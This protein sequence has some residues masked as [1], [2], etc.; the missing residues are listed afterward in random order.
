MTDDDRR[1]V[2]QTARDYFD[3]WFEGDRERM[4]RVLHPRLAKRRAGD[5]GSELVEVPAEDLIDD[6]ASGPQTGYD[7][8]YEVRIVDIGQDMA[9]VVV[10]SDPF[11]EYLHLGRFDGGWRIVNSFYRRNPRDQR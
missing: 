7:R 10:R 4:A 1:A 5:S 11:N 3:S 9:S 6:V 8:T 2:E